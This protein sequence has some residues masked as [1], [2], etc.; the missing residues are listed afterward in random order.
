M[1]PE[2]NNI[3]KTECFK[4]TRQSCL[5]DWKKENIIHDIR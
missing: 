3:Y 1:R 5:K 2:Q 4:Q